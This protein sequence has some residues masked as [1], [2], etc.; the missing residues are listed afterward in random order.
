MPFKSQAQK[1]RFEEMLREGK[2]TQAKFDEWN[3]GTPEKLPDRL[4]AKREK[5]RR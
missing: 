2:I 1:R 5:K 4:H 3:E